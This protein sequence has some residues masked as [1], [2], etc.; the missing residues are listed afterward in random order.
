MPKP[1]HAMLNIAVWPMGRS[2]PLE[3]PTSRA[4]AGAASGDRTINRRRSRV[5]W[6]LRPSASRRGVYGLRERA[7]GRGVDLTQGFGIAANYRSR[8]TGS[9]ANR[10]SG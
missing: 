6:G 4:A 2:A 8:V 1:A 10:H 7:V 9:A 3:P 5:E